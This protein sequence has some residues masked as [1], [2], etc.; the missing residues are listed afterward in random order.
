[1]AEKMVFLVLGDDGGCGTFVL[2]V[3]ASREAAVL[4]YGEGAEIEEMPLHEEAIAPWKY[5]HRVAA[6]YPD[7]HV[8]QS[9][10]ELEGRGECG[11]P[12]CDDH[13]NAGRIWDGHLQSH[14]GEHISV[15]G[16]N[17]EMVESVF[18]ERLAESLARQDGTCHSRHF[19]HRAPVDG[20]TLYQTG[21]LKP[22]RPAERE[23]L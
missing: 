5:Y 2:G 13:L 18:Q 20:V 11:I 10:R 7:K 3:F 1:M 6:V 9:D 12:Q 16:T 17:R 14:C 19:P 8:D 22:P 15:L 21:F 4:T 23:A